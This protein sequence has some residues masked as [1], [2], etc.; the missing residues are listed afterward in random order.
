MAVDKG[1]V[2]ARANTSIG[3]QWRK[4]TSVTFPRVK[5]VTDVRNRLVC[6]GTRTGGDD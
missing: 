4:V 3:R 5:H 6:Y 1:Q 2:I